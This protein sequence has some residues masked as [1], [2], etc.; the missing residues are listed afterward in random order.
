VVEISNLLSLAS[1]LEKQ[2]IEKW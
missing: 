1:M 2:S